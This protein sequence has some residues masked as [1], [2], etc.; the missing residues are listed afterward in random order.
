V[1]LCQLYGADL[2]MEE[3]RVRGRAVHREELPPLRLRVTLSLSHYVT[4]CHCADLRVEEIRYEA[5]QCIVKSY[6]PSVSVADQ[7]P[8]LL[9]EEEEEEEEEEEGEE[10]GAVRACAQWLR[11]HGA[12]LVES[13]GEGEGR[14]ELVFNCKVSGAHLSIVLCCAVLCCA[15]LCCAVLYCTSQ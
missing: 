5:V 1:S 8:P 13:A 12:T 10:E 11:A 6:R 15:V 9:L 3:I 7:H 2:R 14:A 4:V